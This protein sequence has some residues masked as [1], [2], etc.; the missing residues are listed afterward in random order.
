MKYIGW[1]I[2]SFYTLAA[3]A[4]DR[5]VVPGTGTSLY[6]TKIM[7]GPQL[8]SSLSD[9]YNVPLSVL[10][11]Y[12]NVTTTFELR[13]GEEIRIPL[14]R[15]NFYQTSVYGKFQPVYHIFKAGETLVNIAIRYYKIN[16]DSLKNWNNLPDEI[17]VDSKP[18]VIGFITNKRA[19]FS[20]AAYQAIAYDTI[21]NP[22]VYDAA[23]FGPKEIKGEFKPVPVPVPKPPVLLPV[24]KTNNPTEA[25]N[26]ARTTPN[27]SSTS[28]TTFPSRKPTLVTPTLVQT[29]GDFSYRP[30]SNDEGFFAHTYYMRV[31]D[32]AYQAITGDASI[33]KTISGWSDRK[34]YVLI[35]E[36]IP[37]TIVRIT[38]S[39][40]KSVC[41]KVLGPLP[42]TEGAA[43]LVIRMNN[44]AASALGVMDDQ[45]FIVT[46]TYVEY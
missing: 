40:K 14:T 44:A 24:V 19:S 31:K 26:T 34:F 27:N 17:V 28:G 23:K 37:G 8:L 2:I 7:T 42:E 16:I 30:R 39:N 15:D 1:F 43:G 22:N 33:F 20:T 12:N 38:T 11:K 36:I 6:A 13:K 4:Q 29:E 32:R 21:P 45:R 18:L 5:L 10:A 41:A 46:I 25:N 35:N 9:Q 3:A